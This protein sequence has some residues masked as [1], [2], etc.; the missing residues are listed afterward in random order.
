MG[1]SCLTDLRFVVLRF[2]EV[3]S[4]IEVSIVGVDT[5]IGHKSF[6][7]D[8]I[9]GLSAGVIG[10]AM[11]RHFDVPARSGKW[12][13]AGLGINSS[14]LELGDKVKR[15]IRRKLTNPL[16]CDEM[17]HNFFGKKKEKNFGLDFDILI[18][19]RSTPEVWHFKIILG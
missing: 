4:S 9:Y 2:H 5:G 1:S 14:A 3:G 17:F 15:M 10:T 18:L 12:W 16:H 13:N 8:A 7:L 19:F 6:G 11:L